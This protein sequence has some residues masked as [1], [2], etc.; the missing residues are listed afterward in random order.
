MLLGRS[1]EPP[2]LLESVGW[3]GAPLPCQ[4][5]LRSTLWPPKCDIEII[6]AD[7]VCIVVGFGVR[8]GNG[9][10]V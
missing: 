2:T 5:S 1:C 8:L 7:S 10:L 4:T 3:V 9:L 6:Y